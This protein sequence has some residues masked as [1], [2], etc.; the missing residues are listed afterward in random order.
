MYNLFSLLCVCGVCL[1]LCNF[2]TPHSHHHNQDINHVIT[3]ML[4]LQSHNH[5]SHT[6]TLCNNYAIFHM[7]KMLFCKH[8]V[9]EIKQYL[10]FQDWIFFT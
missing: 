1:V 8:Y 5:P 10:S 4:P 2:M 9:D 3:T 6:L 7:Y